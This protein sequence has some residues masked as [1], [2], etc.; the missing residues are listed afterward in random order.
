MAAQKAAKA[1]AAEQAQAEATAAERAVVERVVEEERALAE[2]IAQSVA[3]HAAE[4]NGQRGEGGR[5]T[6]TSTH[7]SATPLV[8]EFHDEFVHTARDN[9]R[10]VYMPNTQLP[11]KYTHSH[12]V[13]IY[14]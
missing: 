12:V 13:A 7:L 9:R 1:A 8:I 3:S 11:R 2:G 14:R 10:Y 4:L 5:P 6:A